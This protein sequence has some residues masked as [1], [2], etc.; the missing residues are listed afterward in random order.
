MGLSDRK[1]CEPREALFA[2]R[3]E[4]RRDNDTERFSI[5]IDGT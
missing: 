3:I 2:E 4:R 5:A 1:I